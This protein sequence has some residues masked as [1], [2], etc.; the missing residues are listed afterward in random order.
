MDLINLNS[1]A[2]NIFS[3]LYMVVA[4]W[5]NRFQSGKI[6]LDAAL[7]KT[8][9]KKQAVPQS[10]SAAEENVS[11]LCTVSVVRSAVHLSAHRFYE[12]A[13]LNLSKLLCGSYLGCSD[14]HTHRQTTERFEVQ[15]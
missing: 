11:S 10:S 12:S 8:K 13:L 5:K 15:E 6:H 2:G 4:K 1:S 7:Q 14:T 9:T 3:K